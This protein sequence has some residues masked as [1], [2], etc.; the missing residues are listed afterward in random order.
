MQGVWVRRLMETFAI[1]TLGDGIIA[2]IFPTEHSLLWEFGP[3]RVR[4]IARFF[5]EN[6]NLMRLLGAAQVAFGI[7]LA[8]RQYH[9]R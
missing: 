6:P 2:V 3:A 8:K 4:K 9:G 7:R 5:A 1:L